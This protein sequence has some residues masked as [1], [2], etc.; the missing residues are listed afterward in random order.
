MI[1]HWCLRSDWES[2]TVDYVSPSL[3]QEGFIHFSYAEQV[4]RTATAID[5][6]A[7]DL[8]LLCVDESGLEVVIED[9]YG[10]G[11]EFPH[12]HGA[13][14]VGTVVK[15]VNFPPQPD[16]TFVLPAEAY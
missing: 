15:V 1:Y 9:S 13:I 2:S 8:V 7:E 4:G 5:R 10:V 6:G 3:A 11:E 12:V 14:P 16:G